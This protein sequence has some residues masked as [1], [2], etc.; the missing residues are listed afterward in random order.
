MTTLPLVMDLPPV[1]PRLLR[2][3]LGSGIIVRTR[4][5]TVRGTLL[6]CVKSSAWLVDDHDTDVVLH[7]DD[8][9]A[10]WAC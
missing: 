10:V 3:L 6:S 2:P 7:L 9:V 4:S 8:M 1:T 5:T